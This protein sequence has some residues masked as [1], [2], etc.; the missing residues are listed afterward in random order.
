MTDIKNEIKIKGRVTKGQFSPD[1]QLYS[2]RMTDQK[3]ERKSPRFAFF[4]ISF[5]LPTLHTFGFARHKSRPFATPK[6]YNFCQHTPT[7]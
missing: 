7:E 4:K 2:G 1:E 6:E 5:C 3:E